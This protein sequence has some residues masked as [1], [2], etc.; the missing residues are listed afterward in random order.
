MCRLYRRQPKS[1]RHRG[2]PPRGVPPTGVPPKRGEEMRPLATR[3]LFVERLG[4]GDQPPARLDGD[5]SVTRL[6]NAQFQQDMVVTG[7]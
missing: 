5:A 7:R 1:R 4:G 3:F 6:A 2:V